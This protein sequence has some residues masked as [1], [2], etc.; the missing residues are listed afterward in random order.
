MQELFWVKEEVSSLDSCPHLEASLERC[1]TAC[2][3]QVETDK[4]TMDMETPAE[5][6]LA[7]ILVEP[8]VK[9]LPLGKVRSLTSPQCIVHI[10]W[11]FTPISVLPSVPSVEHICNLEFGN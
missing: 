1:S 8:G 9:D 3:S 6:F 10:L 5:G 11:V 7:K 2:A 4:A